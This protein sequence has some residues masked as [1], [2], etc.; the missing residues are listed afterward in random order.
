[1]PKNEKYQA[2]D[3]VL[4]PCRE[5]F[6]QTSYF[7]S[8]HFQ[9]VVSS[10]PLGHPLLLHQDCASIIYLEKRWNCTQHAANK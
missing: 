10:G 8:T 6:C 7:T 2:L 5:F 4:K 1:M 9:I 3:K